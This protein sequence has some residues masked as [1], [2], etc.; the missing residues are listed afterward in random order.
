MK[1]SLLL[2][3]SVLANPGFEKREPTAEA[4]L[5]R[6]KREA[7]PA[8]VPVRRNKREAEPAYVPVRRNKREAGTKIP[9]IRRWRR[10]AE[11][12]RD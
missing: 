11:P 7:E 3:A 12:A 8:Y 10:E 1:L 9:P 4:I 5:R 2:L 6:A